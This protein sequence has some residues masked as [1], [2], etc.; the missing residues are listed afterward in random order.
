MSRSVF[1]KIRTTPEC[2]ASLKVRASEAGMRLSTFANEIL[3]FDQ[4]RVNQVKE[5]GE[6]KSQIQTLVAAIQSLRHASS[7][8]NDES[9][10][11][12]T[13]LRLL[14][15]ELALHFDAQ[16]VARVAAQIKIQTHSKENL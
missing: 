4:E 1:L 2:L 10:L 11:A 6:L 16:I 8:I 13:E 9:K 12:L 3:E 14:I 7:T 15:R 5:L